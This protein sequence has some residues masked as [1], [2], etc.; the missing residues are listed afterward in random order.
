MRR[1]KI[2]SE[3]EK[4]EWTK[5]MCHMPSLRI[6]CFD[7]DWCE[8]FPEVPW[9]VSITGLSTVLGKM[10]TCRENLWDYEIRPGLRSSQVAEVRVTIHTPIPEGD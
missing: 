10:L 2:L 3:E 6:Q 9:I 8:F 7:K 4:S 1:R 5:R